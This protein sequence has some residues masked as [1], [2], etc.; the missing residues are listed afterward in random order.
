MSEQRTT[1]HAWVNGRCVTCGTEKPRPRAEP[2][3]PETRRVFDL[4]IWR[5]TDLWP[6]RR[7]FTPESDEDRNTFRVGPLV[8]CWTWRRENVETGERA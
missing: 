7:G 6:V 4:S 8:I 1:G 3:P 2:C 5:H